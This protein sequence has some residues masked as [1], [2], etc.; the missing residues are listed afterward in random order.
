MLVVGAGSIGLDIS[1]GAACAVTFAREGAKVICADSS[2]AA[3]NDT[4][5]RIEDIGGNAEAFE[6]DVRSA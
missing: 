5:R 1:N 3:A 6:A 2:F 4:V